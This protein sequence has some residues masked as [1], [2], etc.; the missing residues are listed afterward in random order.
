MS[1]YQFTE[2]VLLGL[3]F[4]SPWIAAVA[5]LWPR[6]DRNGAVPPSMGELARRRWIS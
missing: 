2:T 5:L 1:V 6:L 3:L 4:A